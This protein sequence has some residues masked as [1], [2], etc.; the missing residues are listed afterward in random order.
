MYCTCCYGYMCIV[1]TWDGEK[2]SLDVREKES[3]S[4]RRGRD[5]WDEEYDRGKVGVAMGVSTLY[6]LII[7]I[8]IIIQA[9]KVKKQQDGGHHKDRGNPFQQ[10]Y[11]NVS[12]C[13]LV[14]N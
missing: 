2:S 13:G 9:K 8:V 1:Q 4:R 3:G 5:D 11:K 6:Q 12:G 10:H 7:I 14:T